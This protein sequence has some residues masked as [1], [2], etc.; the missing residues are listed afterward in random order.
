MIN[1]QIYTK[2]ILMTLLFTVSFMWVFSCED[3]IPDTKMNFT[4]TPSDSLQLLKINE[5]T[6]IELNQSNF[7]D[8]EIMVTWSAD[9]GMIIGNGLHAFY[10][11]PSEP[12]TALVQAYLKDG[13]NDT[14]IDSIIIIIYKQLIILKAD[15]FKFSQQHIIPLGFQR[16][17]EFIESKKIKA[18]IGI[19]GNTLE[20]GHQEYFTIL[21]E[22]ADDGSFEIW[23]H[24]YNHKLNGINEN[25]ETYH[26]FWNTTFEYQKEH[27]EETQELA[28]EKLSITLRAFG[29]PGN[30][31]DSITLDVMNE[32]DEIK[33][34]FYGNPESNKIV[35]ER[36]Y[37]I[38]FSSQYPDYEEFVNNY[39]ANEEYLA[40]QIHPN[41][42]DNEGFNQFELI[43]EFLMTQKVAFITPD[44][45]YRLSEK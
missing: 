42:W 11:A 22:I 19:I 4:L 16:F 7:N 45:F 31:H 12:C 3:M 37:N 43:V 30:N 20:K 41:A 28:F 27:L 24:G 6:E 40:L 29:A 13:N 36:Y 21:K 23:N 33:V 34:W 15:D 25:G 14:S 17:I 44:E 26:E 32:N 5:S 8:P 2:I 39:P 10:S 1:K 18:S 9:T 38:E 35:L